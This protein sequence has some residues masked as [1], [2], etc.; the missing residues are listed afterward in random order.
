MLVRG[1]LSKLA[2]SNLGALC[3]T[4]VHA[5]DVLEALVK[6]GVTS[7]RDFNWI[8]QLRYYYEEHPDDYERYGKVGQGLACVCVCVG[9]LCVCGVRLCEVCVC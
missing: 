1:S 9:L 2:R 6:E 3:V 7:P 5:R 4:D 8:A